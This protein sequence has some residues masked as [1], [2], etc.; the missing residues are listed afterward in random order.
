VGRVGIDLREE[1]DGCQGNVQDL[2]LTLSSRRENQEAVRVPGDVGRDLWVKR[3]LS[4]G[5]YMPPYSSSFFTGH[6]RRVF[7]L[8]A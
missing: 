5:M 6:S 4:L 1:E 2:E 8:S 3:A 7:S